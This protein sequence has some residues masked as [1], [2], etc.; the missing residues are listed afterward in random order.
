ML[1][2]HAYFKETIYESPQEYFRVRPIDI[3]Y[4]L[5]DDSIAVYEPPVDNSGIPQ[6][7]LFI[8]F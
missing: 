4:F 8:A 5:E 2:F 6:G 1:R 7:R 3:Y